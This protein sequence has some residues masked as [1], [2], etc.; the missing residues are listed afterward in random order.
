MLASEVLAAGVPHLMLPLH[1]ETELNATLVL[2]SAA[3]RS[4]DPAASAPQFKAGLDAFVAD[5][6]LERRTS[7]LARLLTERP[8]PDAGDE[9]VSALARWTSR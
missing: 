9:L 7:N 8:L 5:V 1:R 3:G 2:R 6:E 4:M